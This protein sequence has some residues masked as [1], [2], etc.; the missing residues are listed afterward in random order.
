MQTDF[1]LQTAKS[2]QN[3]LEKTKPQVYIYNSQRFKQINIVKN[4][5]TH[6]RSAYV[7]V[8]NNTGIATLFRSLIIT[9]C[10]LGDVFSFL[11]GLC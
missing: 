2:A 6:V 7:F 5:Q 4:R 8:S 10:S 11:A 3:A 1:L 9:N